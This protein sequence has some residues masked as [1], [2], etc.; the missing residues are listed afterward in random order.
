[1]TARVEGGRELRRTLRK[2]GLDMKNL[3]AVNK[4]AAATVVRAALPATPRRG[5][6]LAQSV[7]AGATQRAGIVR[8]GRKAM[9]YAGPI[10]WGWP[11][12]GIAPQPWLMTA[13]KATEPVWF[14][15]YENEIKD[16]LKSVKGLK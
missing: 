3:T 14:R 16:L 4:R 10:H 8:A 2:A 7:R 9:P 5:G 11:A 15:Q 1:M 13:A 6:A 12:R